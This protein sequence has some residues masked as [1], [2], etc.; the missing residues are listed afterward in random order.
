MQLHRFRVE[1]FRP[2]AKKRLVVFPAEALHGFLLQAAPGLSFL[3]LDRC[4]TRMSQTDTIC[5]EP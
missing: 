3:I 4:L 1:E 5:R 2:G